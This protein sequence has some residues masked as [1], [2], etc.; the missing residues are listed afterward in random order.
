MRVKPI[1]TL[2]LIASALALSG[3]AAALGLGKLTVLSSL[4]QPLVAQIALPSATREELDSLAAKVAD[5]TLYRQN[6]LNYQGVLTR[7]RV[8]LERSPS[9]ESFLK[10]TTA[11][12]VNEPY[13]DLLVEVNW[14][15][16]RIVREYTFLLDP[17]GVSA[18]APVE[19][20]TPLRA[21]AAPRGTT[22][23]T[24]PAAAPAAPRAAAG[25][26]YTVR[27]G[28]TLSRIASEVKP[29]SVSL[30]QMLVALFKSNANAFDGNNMNRLRTGAIV[31]VPSA[32]EAASTPVSEAAKTIRVQAADWRAYRDRV[33]A[34]APMADGTGGRAAAGQIGTAVQEKT[35]AARPGGDQLRVSREPGA[36]KG[37]GAAESAV[38]ADKQLKEAQA[39]IAE[40]ERTLKDMQ[41]AVEL[42]NQSMAQLQEQADAA[43]GKA[44]APATPAP[45]PA[46]KAPE[47][48]K[49]EPPKATPISPA[50]APVEP[51]KAQSRPRPSRR[52]P[53]NPRRSSRRR[54]QSRPRPSRRRPPNPLRSSR[55]RPRN[56]RRWSRRRSHRRRRRKRPRSRSASRASSTICSPTPR[57][58]R[59]AAARSRY[60]AASLR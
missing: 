49:V 13:L 2:S 42:K 39:R 11:A 38:A 53:R 20:V 35:P 12:P 57:R 43:K 10:V 28:D 36:G 16:G 58:G 14:A 21:G 9:G 23:T 52:R 1:F 8:S 54:Q 48:A 6:N 46:A 40:L 3:T 32:E 34:A 17:P 55:R 51:P 7:A 22:T 24:A 47:P 37:A 26:G 45:A 50:P 59:S 4:G 56:R 15:S 27:R 19:P 5:P 31:T 44:A 18:P 41:R 33:A 25:E 29:A 60:S 30:E